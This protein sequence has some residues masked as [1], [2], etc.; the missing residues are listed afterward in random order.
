MKNLSSYLIAVSLSLAFLPSLFSQDG[1]LPN[2]EIKVVREFDARLLESKAVKL[3]G[4]FLDTENIQYDLDYSINPSVPMIDYEAPIIR[5]IAAS[6]NPPD[7]GYRH[8]VQVGVGLPKALFVDAQTNLLVGEDTELKAWVK[9]TSMNADPKIEHK[10]TALNN[11]GVEGTH[12]ISEKTRVD[13]KMDYDLNSFRWYAFSDS[14]IT[15]DDFDALQRFNK[16]SAEATL[17]QLL[18]EGS[19]TKFEVHGGF[20][21][22][23]NN[24]AT[25][26]NGVNIN[27]KGSQ[28]YDNHSVL[29]GE[30]DIDA[31]TMRDTQIHKLNNFGITGGYN[32]KLNQHNFKLGAAIISSNDKYHLFPKIHVNLLINPSHSLSVN[33]TGGLLKNNYLFL[34]ETNPFI[35]PRFGQINNNK[36]FDFSLAINNRFEHFKLD[37]IAGF[38]TNSNLALWIPNTENLRAFNTIYD[39]VN[40]TYIKAVFSA[41]PTEGITIDAYF[42]QNFNKLNFQ[43]KA[44]GVPTTLAEVTSH[45]T[46]M[47]KKLLGSIGFTFMGNIHQINYLSEAEKSNTLLDFNIGCKYFIS[48]QLGLFLN[49]NNIINN[50]YQRWYNTPTFGANIMAGVVLRL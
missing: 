13:A 27:F 29:Y 15:L 14:L 35:A 31:S 45:I 5:P 44:W 21:R 42:Q 19:N 43:E 50:K 18:D 48:D 26:E 33:A 4:I 38:K 34:G 11:F 20:Y 7:E 40:T 9:H 3:P 49:A 37:L 17:I 47:E 1:S 6:V 12:F 28:V 2:E 36:V 23:S 41:T 25:R 46:L 24:H 39:T 32:F 30:L 22:F 8:L 10:K 16:L